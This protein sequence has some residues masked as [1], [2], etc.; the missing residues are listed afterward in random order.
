MKKIAKRMYALLLALLLVLSLAACGKNGGGNNGQQPDAPGQNQNQDQDQNTP[1]QDQDQDQDQDAPS[2][3]APDLNQYYEDLMASLGE[4]NQP[5][6]MDVEAEMV[7]QVYP[8]LGALE[9]KQLVAKTP[10]ITSVAFELV[11]VELAD[12]AD[13]QAA[14]DILQAR[15]DY[16][17]ESGAF[18]PA[19]VEAWENA[20]ILTQGNV[21]A[22]I[23]AGAEQERAVEA[24][25]A[26][27]A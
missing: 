18:Y 19:T 25:N 27:F 4:D 7:E 8:G 23:C 15:I 2:Q 24:F 26:L 10:M 11:L 3:D 12:E 14:Q 9:T 5:A 13:V 16:Q 21:V 1:N 6:M 17:I 20:Q 22:L